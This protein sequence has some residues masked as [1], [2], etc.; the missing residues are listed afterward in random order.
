MRR[1]YW[2]LVL[3]IGHS[4]GEAADVEYVR[5]V[6]PLLARKCVACHGPLKQQ[7]GLRLDAGK[8]IHR[9]GDGGRVVVVGSPADSPILDRI[10]ALEPAERMPPEGAG[11]PL[12][13]EEVATL[14]S[15]IAT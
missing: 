6:K 4:A 1:L 5:D 12:S 11:E 2:L 13:P 14:K 7:A 3:T 9:G 10:T 8:L 15:W